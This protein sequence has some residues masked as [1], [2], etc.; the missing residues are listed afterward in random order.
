MADDDLRNGPKLI[1]RFRIA[2]RSRHMSIHT[3]KAYWGWV[4]RYVRFHGLQHPLE[5]G[6]PHI[7]TFLSHLAVNR[8]VAPS[9]QNQA[10]SALL[11][12]YREV[13][14]IPVDEIGVFVRPKRRANIPVV[15]TRQEVSALLGH[16]R[17]EPY[18]IA[19]LLYGSGLRLAEALSLRVKDIDFGRKQ[20]IVRAGKGDKEREIGRA[21]V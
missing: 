9:T 10:L 12:L 20:V 1:D 19:S 2:C 4:I 11:F 15:L 6:P 3:E 7:Q 18:L 8:N 14:G 17:G 21:H 16:L 13:L 5:L